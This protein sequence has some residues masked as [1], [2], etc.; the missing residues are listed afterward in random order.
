MWAADVLSGA[1]ND[2][3]GSNTIGISCSLQEALSNGEMRETIADIEEASVMVWETDIG[4]NAR[5]KIARSASHCKERLATLRRLV[6]TVVSADP[7]DRA[8]A[9]RASAHSFRELAEEWGQQQQQSELDELQ[10]QQQERQAV[11]RGPLA[12][13]LT[14]CDRPD[15]VLVETT[16]PKMPFSHQA[17]RAD[18]DGT[19]G[20]SKNS[21]NPTKQQQQPDNSSDGDDD[22][23]DM[24]N[25]QLEYDE[26]VAEETD[27]QDEH[28]A[29]FGGWE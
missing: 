19:N 24:W 29:F 8:A 5:K 16:G 22:D 1:F 13:V 21:T 15:S 6:K 11:S 12:G 27:L 18:L 14:P 28:E 25:E 10:Q 17:S 7:P 26:V 9:F 2:S 20:G 23:D 3:R 4:A